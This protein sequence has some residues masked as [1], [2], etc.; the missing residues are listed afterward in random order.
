MPGAVV[1]NSVCSSV[2]GN[3]TV[4]KIMRAI[5]LEKEE[6]AGNTVPKQRLRNYNDY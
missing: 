3:E 4:D 6:D 5:N 2:V 1:D